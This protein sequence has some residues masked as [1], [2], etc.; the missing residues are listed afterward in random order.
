MLDRFRRGSKRLQWRGLTVAV[1]TLAPLASTTL[2]ASAGKDHDKDEGLKIGD[3]GTADLILY[4]G[5]ISTVDKR[6]STVEAIAIRDG[7]IMATGDDHQVKKLADR[8]TELIDLN[9]RRVLP[10]LI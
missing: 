3:L 7:E 10:G 8:N 5:K 1:A 6:N 4:D 2:L 9:D